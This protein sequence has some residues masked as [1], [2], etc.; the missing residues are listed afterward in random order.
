[1]SQKN[2]LQMPYKKQELPDKKGP[3]LI[4]CGNFTASSPFWRS[5]DKNEKKLE[6]ESQ[7]LDFVAKLAACSEE[8][9]SLRNNQ[10]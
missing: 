8:V 1:M 4:Q 10:S 5:S 2:K 6:S 3:Y 9:R 7:M